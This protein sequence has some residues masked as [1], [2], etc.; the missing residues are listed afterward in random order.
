MS[1][2]RRSE[3]NVYGFGVFAA[4]DIP[5]GT[6]IAEFDGGFADADNALSLPISR[7]GF[8]GRHAVQC[9][10]RVW[11][12]GNVDGIAR[13]IAHSCSPNCGIKGYFKIVTKRDIPVGE[14]LTWDY[15]MTEDSELP[16]MKCLCRKINCRGK[17]KSFSG[18]TP[19]ER[20]E[21]IHLNRG[22]ISTWLVKK[23]S[24]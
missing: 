13:Y 3:T 16:D 9:A 14:E 19:T 10:E 2:V 21:F 23:Y 22:F 24:L 6:V 18:M 1:K 15:A 7:Q 20:A 11:R 4:E 5:A 12:D 17:I 8:D